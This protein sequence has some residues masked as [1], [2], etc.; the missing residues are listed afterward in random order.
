[1]LNSLDK[2]I[3][4]WPSITFIVILSFLIGVT[5]LKLEAASP[6]KYL[7]SLLSVLRSEGGAVSTEG[8]WYSWTKDS[9]NSRI[10]DSI[11][12]P[13]LKMKWQNQFFKDL[14]MTGAWQDGN[15]YCRDGTLVLVR[16][17][18]VEVYDPAT[19]ESF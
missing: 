10:A 19:G 3:S 11:V 6:E 12:A 16:R 5:V 8:E 15:L 7:A 2:K 4:F 13:P 17:Y 9:H 14:S 1:M 18:G